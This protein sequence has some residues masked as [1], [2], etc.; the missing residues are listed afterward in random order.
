[1]NRGGFDVVI[2]N[3][4]YIE[5]RTIRSQYT[6]RV[7]ETESCGNLYAFTFERCIKITRPIGRVGMIIPVSAVCTTGYAPLQRLLHNSGISVVSNFNDR[8]SKLFDGLEHNR[9]C[10]ILHQKRADF[11]LTY[12]AKYLKWQSEERPTLFYCLA[13]TET[14]DLNRNESM[15]KIGTAIEAS[16]LKKINLKKTQL[17]N[18]ISRDG[19]FSIYYTRKLSHFVQ[20]LDFVPKITDD[21]KQER[22]P[23]ELKTITFRNQLER[24]VFLSILNS[25]TFYW[26]LIVYSDCRNLNKREVESVRFDPDNANTNLQIELGKLCKN[27]MKDIANK[28]RTLTMNYKAMGRL[29]IQCTYPRLSK[30]FIDSID[31]ILSKHYGFTDEEL[32]FIINYDIK[33]RMGIENGPSES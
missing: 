3:P 31:R 23:S 4:P 6:I 29:H 33:Y 28:S 12:S 19:N 11:G 30:Q 26:L 1:M 16:I 20:V 9:L 25:S 24:D 27:L 14:T 2:G 7:Y 10:I 17:G 22:L 18:C 5:Y 32:D 13:F 21:N 15:A 8:P